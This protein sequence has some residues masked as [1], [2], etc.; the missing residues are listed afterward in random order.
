MTRNLEK[1][2]D[3]NINYRH[4]LFVQLILIEFNS[5]KNIDTKQ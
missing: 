5:Y 3:V 4:K 2:C 1:T